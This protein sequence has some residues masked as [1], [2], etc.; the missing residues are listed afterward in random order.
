MKR[1]IALSER[2]TIN[3][4]LIYRFAHGELNPSR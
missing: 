4:S 2:G 3:Q 1:L